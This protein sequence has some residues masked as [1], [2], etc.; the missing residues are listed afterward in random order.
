V[1]INLGANYLLGPWTFATQVRWRSS[2]ALNGDPTVYFDGSSIPSN[3][4]ADLTATYGFKLRGKAFQ[5]FVSVQNLF[6]QLAH[7]Y[8]STVQAAN[9]GGGNTIVPGDDVIGRYF[10]AG[11]RVRF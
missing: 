4:V 5:G 9:F 1:K 10:T 3:V 7:S 8:A 2:L 6:D 11:L